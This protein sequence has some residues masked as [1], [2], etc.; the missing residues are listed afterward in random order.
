MKWPFFLYLKV[1]LPLLQSAHAMEQVT[2]TLFD[3]R[4]K[5]GKEGGNVGLYAATL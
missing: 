3:A 5:E 2:Q 1:C 4:M